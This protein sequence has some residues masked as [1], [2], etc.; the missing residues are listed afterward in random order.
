[1]QQGPIDLS[2]LARKL[3]GAFPRPSPDESAIAL[4]VFR[5]LAR[6]RPAEIH[7]IAEQ[8]DSSAVLVQGTLADWPSLVWDDRGRVMG[9]CGL[10]LQATRHRIGLG[11]R[12]LYA[13][14]A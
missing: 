12:T 2:D 3:V 5:E 9:F 10:G 4:A 6:G 13:W 1:M 7:G 14:C 11:D 8:A